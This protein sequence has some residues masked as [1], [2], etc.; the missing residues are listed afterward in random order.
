MKPRL[1]VLCAGA[2]NRTS[3]GCALERAGAEPIIVEDRFEN[4]D[5]I[6]FPGVAHFGYLAEQLD[7]RGW[8]A[9]ILDAIDRGVPF[10]GICAGAQLLFAR[11]EEA[12]GARGLG[13]FPETVRALAGPRSQHMGWN[14][15]VPVGNGVARG[16]GYFAHAFAPPPAATATV[17]MSVYGKPFASVVRSCSVMGV[18]FHPER[19]GAYGAGILRGFVLHVQARNAR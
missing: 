1:A 7:A 2:G 15:V 16:W 3:I 8:R 9:P 10:L 14:A 17:A 6:V 4:A 11:S 19:S 18:Q 13:V 5:A 12:R